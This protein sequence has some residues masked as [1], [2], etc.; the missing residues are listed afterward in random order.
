MRMCGAA[1]AY[2]SYNSGYDF[3]TLPER[4]SLRFGTEYQGRTLKENLAEG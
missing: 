4:F 2:L 3:S 1:G